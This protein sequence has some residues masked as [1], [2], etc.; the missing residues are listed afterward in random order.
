[1]CLGNSL[2]VHCVVDNDLFKVNSYLQTRKGW[3]SLTGMELPAVDS[4]LF[5]MKCMC[6]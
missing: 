6:L 4:A 2:E 3:I 1:V 5:Q